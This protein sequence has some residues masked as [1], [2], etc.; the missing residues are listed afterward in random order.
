MLRQGA[1]FQV[2]RGVWATPAHPE[3]LWA[4]G[5]EIRLGCLKVAAYVES[6][7]STDALARRLGG[8]L[9]HDSDREST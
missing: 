4:V 2:L 3:K 8:G 9:V 1:A 5:H 7:L 6:K